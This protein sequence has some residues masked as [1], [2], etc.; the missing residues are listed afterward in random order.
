MEAW[1]FMANVNRL[2]VVAAMIGRTDLEGMRAQIAHADTVAPLFDS[3]LRG[4]G[5]A[6][7]DALRRFVAA[8]ESFRLAAAE[9]LR[10]LAETGAPLPPVPPQLERAESEDG[11]QE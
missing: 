9:Y 2:G 8:S 4:V 10:A 1:E 7:L 11:H 3:S 6:R 5:I